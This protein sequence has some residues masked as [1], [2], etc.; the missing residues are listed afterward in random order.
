MR[1]TQLAAECGHCQSLHISCQ[2]CSVNRI[3]MYSWIADVSD[4]SENGNFNFQS[5]A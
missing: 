5:Q 4:E 3:Y 2:T 1:N